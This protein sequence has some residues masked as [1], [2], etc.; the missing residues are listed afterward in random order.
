MTEESAGSATPEVSARPPGKKR[1]PKPRAEVEAQ[2][3]AQ[4]E[5]ELREKVEAEIR[6]KVEAEAAEKE[7]RLEAIR[8]AEAADTK[9]VSAS[10]VDGDPSA[11]GAVTIHFLEDGFTKFGRVWF[12]GEH[13]TLNPNTEQWKE[14]ED[15][16]TGKVF[17]LMGE[18][19]QIERWGRRL[20]RQGLWKGMR[21]DQIDDPS[22]T[23]EDKALLKKA[24]QDFDRKYGAVAR[25]K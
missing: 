15:P 9:P 6:A 5:A 8:A 11:E 24:Q 13:L 1:G 19:E 22:L 23:E 14:A 12:R 20:F 17:A 18:D 4:V 10:D 16:Q 2:I 25:D 7:K 3:R 21:W